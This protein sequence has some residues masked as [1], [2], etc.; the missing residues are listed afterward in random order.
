MIRRARGARDREGVPALLSNRPSHPRPARSGTTRTVP[1]RTANH[2]PWTDRTTGRATF[3][4]SRA[5]RSG[6]EDDLDVSALDALL[7]DVGSRRRRRP[8]PR[9]RTPGLDDALLAPPPPTIGLRH[10]RARRRR[11]RTPPRADLA[12]RR[13]TGDRSGARAGSPASSS[14]TARPPLWRTMWPGGTAPNA[15]RSLPPPP[16]APGRPPR[17]PVRLGHGAAVRSGVGRVVGAPDR[18]RPARRPAAL[19]LRGGGHAGRRSGPPLDLDRAG[20]RRRRAQPGRHLDGVGAS[21]RW[22]SRWPPPSSTA[23][24]TSARSWPCSRCRRCCGPTR[25][26]SP[27]CPRCACGPR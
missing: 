26:A 5:P 20:R 22:S 16:D 1:A 11:V 27:G 7:A 14:S 10:R 23:A 9:S 15:E 2:H 12:A 6:A 18:R 25:S 3:P 17:A 8:T 21:S 19:R 13:P 4:T 24:G